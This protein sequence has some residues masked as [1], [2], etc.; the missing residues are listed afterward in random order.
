M[1]VDNTSRLD[2][3]FYRGAVGRNIVIIFGLM[4]MGLTS[5]LFYLQIIKGSYHQKLSE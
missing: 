2:D 5:R 4:L 3:P 1:R